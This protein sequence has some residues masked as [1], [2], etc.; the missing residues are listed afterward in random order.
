MTTV[1]ILK[2]FLRRVKETVDGRNVPVNVLLCAGVNE[3]CC[4]A[5]GT[6]AFADGDRS[7]DAKRR[8]GNLL[9]LREGPPW[10]RC[11]ASLIREAA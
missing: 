5:G 3:K 10:A 7:E 9:L 4:F 11:C 2:A 6:T 1:L 8:S